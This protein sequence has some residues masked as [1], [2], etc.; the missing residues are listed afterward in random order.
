MSCLT[1]DYAA[2]TMLSLSALADQEIINM[3]IDLKVQSL[4]LV[5][6]KKEYQLAKASVTAFE[7]HVSTRDTNFDVKGQLGSVSLQDSSPNGN[8]YRERFITTG[9]KAVDFHVFKYSKISQIIN[10]HTLSVYLNSDYSSRA[11]MT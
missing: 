9:D 6:N 10:A 5:L 11:L 7:A 1:G 8:L 2:I 4:S 3:E